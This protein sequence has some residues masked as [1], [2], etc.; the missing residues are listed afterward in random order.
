MGEYRTDNKAN[1]ADFAMPLR[2]SAKPLVFVF[3][4]AI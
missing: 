1:A 2:V 4:E 3:G